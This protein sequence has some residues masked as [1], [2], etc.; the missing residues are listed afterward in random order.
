MGS[1]MPAAVLSQTGDCE[2]EASRSASGGWGDKG[3]SFTQWLECKH[4]RGAVTEIQRQRDG[5]PVSAGSRSL[6][7]YGLRYMETC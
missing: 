6:E 3:E 2:D 5:A 1:P 4:T 7:N